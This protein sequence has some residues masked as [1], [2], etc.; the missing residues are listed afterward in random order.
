MIT[1][2]VG[3]KYN[4]PLSGVKAILIAR[5]LVDGIMA[6]H[7]EFW[8]H[9]EEPSFSLSLYRRYAKLFEFRR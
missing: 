1:Q 8:F 3:V 7:D 5:L 2:R 9:I 6:S 4:F